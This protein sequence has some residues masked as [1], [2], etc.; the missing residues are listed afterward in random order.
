[1]LDYAKPYIE[2]IHYIDQRFSNFISLR[3]TLINTG[4]SRG[5]PT[6]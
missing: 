6:L 2:K 4:F 5:T 3:H 1:M